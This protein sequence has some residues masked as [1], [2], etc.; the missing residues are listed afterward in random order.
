MGSLRGGYPSFPNTT[1]GDCASVG[2]R[3]IV[4]P[5][6]H[7]RYNAAVLR[8]N[9]AS[10]RKRWALSVFSLLSAARSEIPHACSLC[11]SIDTC[12]GDSGGPIMMFNANNKWETGRRGQLRIWVCSAGASWCL[13]TPHVLQGLDQRNHSKRFVCN[14]NYN[15][16]Q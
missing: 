7:Q 14:N 4:L 8:R 16:C 6:R 9:H 11:L 13:H 10:G 1:A 2:I 15:W 12:Q 3:G 5:G